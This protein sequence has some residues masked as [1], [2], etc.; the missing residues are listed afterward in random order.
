MVFGSSHRRNLQLVVKSQDVTVREWTHCRLAD[1]WGVGW[2]LH[3]AA[4]AWLD[5]QAAKGL[6]KC[7]TLGATTG[8]DRPTCG[9]AATEGGRT[10]E[11]RWS[12]VLGGPGPAH[13]LNWPQESLGRTG[14]PGLSYFLR[15]TPWRRPD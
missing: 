11:P 9:V 14:P 8:G 3:V 1:T 13:L 10:I 6:A 7:Q 12:R 15:H 4:G 5:S 2:A